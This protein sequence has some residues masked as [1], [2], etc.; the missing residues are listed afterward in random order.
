MLKIS[1]EGISYYPET[2][3]NENYLY[4]RLLP[5]EDYTIDSEAQ[6]NNETTLLQSIIY[7]QFTIS[8]RQKETWFSGFSKI[9]SAAKIVVL[10]NGRAY[11]MKLSSYESTNIVR[12]FKQVTL[13][14]YAEQIDNINS[15]KINQA[16]SRMND[17]SEFKILNSSI[18]T[19]TYST[20][21]KILYDYDLTQNEADNFKKKITDFTKRKYSVDIRLVLDQSYMGI[22]LEHLADVTYNSSGAYIV[23]NSTTFKEYEILQNNRIGDDLYIVDLRLYYLSEIKTLW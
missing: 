13:K 4:G 21:F 15:F 23:C 9:K 17:V 16:Y 12:D 20:K 10:Y 2:Y 14:L 22:F 6:W 1:F 11:L 19:F 8:L 3:K 5:V 18:G 7:P